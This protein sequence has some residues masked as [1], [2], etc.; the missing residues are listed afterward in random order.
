MHIC[1]LILSQNTVRFPTVLLL[2]EALDFFFPLLA[3]F[4][5]K[6]SPVLGLE[7]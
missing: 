4:F 6:E 2:S 1:K 5:M 3:F 7:M